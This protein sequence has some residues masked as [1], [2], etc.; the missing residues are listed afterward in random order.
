[1]RTRSDYAPALACAI[2]LALSQSAYSQTE[3]SPVEPPSSG[4]RKLG[5]PAPAGQWQAPSDAAL[6]PVLTLPAGTWIKIRVDQ[7]L[8]SDRN[9]P[10]DQFTATLVQ[11]LVVSGFV[12]ARAGQTVGGRITSVEKAGR[13]K[14]TSRM[15][16]ELTEVDLADGSQ[17]PIHSQLIEYAGPTSKGRDATAIA[18]ATG[19]G[20]AVGAA[21]G[22]GFGAGMGAIAGAAASVVGVLVTRGVPVQVYPESVL[23]FRTLDPVDIP[24][25]AGERAFLPVAPQDYEQPPV[26]RRVTLPAPAP[27]PPPYGP[28]YPY[29]W[30]G[31]WGYPPYWYGPSVYFYS[32]PVFFGSFGYGFGGRLHGWRR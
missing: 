27:Y 2:L 31:P 18:A 32:G 6:P 7:P 29:Y 1:M 30:G 12:V 3:S 11:P 4:W 5:D 28:P 23:T 13:V 26:E 15:G 20:A 24:T 14:G 22:G 17:L 8:S 25:G 10:G 9:H 21:A 19:T 16:I